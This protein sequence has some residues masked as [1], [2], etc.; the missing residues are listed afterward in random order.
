MPKLFARLSRL[1]LCGAV[2]AT[3]VW[4]VETRQQNRLPTVHLPTKAEQGPEERGMDLVA[5]MVR[6]RA[7]RFQMG[8][9]F[10]GAADQ[11]PA[12]EVQINEFWFDRHSVTNRQFAAFVAATLYLTT[13]EQIGR[14]SGG[15]SWKVPSGATRLVR[16]RRS[17]VAM[18]SRSYKFR[19][20]MRWLTLAG[21][22]VGCRPKPSGICS[23][24]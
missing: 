13:A 4:I 1:V 12:H 10:T 11:R 20:T 19:G 16:L 17:L 2:I 9:D 7:G 24:W 22:T 3:I 5:G 18:I 15:W 23:A 14:R 6:I 8:S 21:L